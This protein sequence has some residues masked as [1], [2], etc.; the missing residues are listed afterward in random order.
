LKAAQYAAQIEM[1]AVIDLEARRMGIDV[2][3]RDGKLHRLP[4][5]DQQT[6]TL[7]RSCATRM[8]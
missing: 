7:A 5:T 8:R 3:E 4:S 2:P 6:A 1:G